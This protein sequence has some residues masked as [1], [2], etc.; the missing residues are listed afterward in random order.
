MRSG[1]VIALLVWSIEAI[2]FDNN[3]CG[4]DIGDGYLGAYHSKAFLDQRKKIEPFSERVM[5]AVSRTEMTLSIKLKSGKTKAFR[6]IPCDGEDQPRFE[7]YAQALG[8][9]IVR[10]YGW[11]NHKVFLVDEKTGRVTVLPDTSLPVASPDGKHF[12]VFGDNFEHSHNELQVWR[13]TDTGPQKLW[14]NEPDDVRH[15]S[16]EWKSNSRLSVVF[17]P[18]GEDISGNAPPFVTPKSKVVVDG[19]RITYAR[20]A[21]GG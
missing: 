4:Y 21:T 6:G 3:L 9:F 19:I 15:Y 11:E 2:A 13:I 16:V 12:A 7:G 14:A 1:L 17:H 10:S 8:L 5:I 20:R 18:V